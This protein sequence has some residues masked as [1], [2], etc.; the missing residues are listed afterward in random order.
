VI[1]KD[2]SDAIYLSWNGNVLPTTFVSSTEVQATIPA[3]A[4]TGPTAAPLF[5]SNSPGEGIAT[6]IAFTVLPI[7]GNGA[8]LAALNV[9]GSDLVWDATAGAL[10]VAANST[11]S[12]NPRTITTI[13]PAMGT[14]KASTP[15][16]GNPYVLAISEANRYLYAGFA[17][18]PFIQRYALP[19]L[20]P[21]LLIPLGIGDNAP[22]DYVPGSPGSCSFAVSIGVAPG[23][24]TTIAAM[25]GNGDGIEPRG[26]GPAVVIDGA[27]P[28]PANTG[29]FLS[30]GH[31]LSAMTWGHDATAV[32]T[33]GIPGTT[34]QPISSLTVSNTGIAFNRS[35]TA[36][37]YLGYRPHFDTGTGLIYSDGGAV[38]RPSDLSQ[39]GNFNASG[40]MVP[41]S[42]LGR[43]YFLGQTPS[44]TTS[45]AQSSTAFTL[46]IYD[47]ETQVLLDSIVIPNVIGYPNQMVRWGSSGIAFTTENGDYQGN[48]APGLTYILNAPEI[49]GTIPAAKQQS[50]AGATSVHLTWH[51]RKQGKRSAA[52]DP[53][54][55]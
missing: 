24:E 13:D 15:T 12:L 21:D 17:D 51:P 55:P 53:N 4:L 35:S 36:D 9:S 20:T 37:A 3:A 25:Q 42:K 8:Q 18:Y 7:L 23:A 48:N 49:S 22:L 30:T 5:V 45:N 43:A 39:V 54:M 34:F 29:T 11:D 44:Q 10:Y 32:Y 33:Q 2:F 28:R 46:Q 16:L 27:T 50:L 6:P 38:T 14:V 41:D 19:G 31:D 52:N 1:G 26:C 47:L 40:L